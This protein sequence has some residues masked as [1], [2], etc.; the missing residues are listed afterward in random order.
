MSVRKILLAVASVVLLWI[1]AA[2]LLCAHGTV[3]GLDGQVAVIDNPRLWDSMDII[4]R[5][6]YT[7]GDFF[8]H[9]MESRSFMLNGNQLP[10]C[11]RDVALLAGFVI[12]IIAVLA[13]GIRRSRTT[14]TIIVSSFALIILDWATQKIFSSDVVFTR[15]LTGLLAGAAIAMFVCFLLD[16]MNPHAAGEE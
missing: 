8:C 14:D 13:L 4:P 15:V 9:Q 16:A 5:T 1:I 3:T 7:L 12:G 6:I 2:P 10:F 11:V